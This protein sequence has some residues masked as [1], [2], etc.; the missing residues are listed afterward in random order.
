MRLAAVCLLLCCWPLPLRAQPAP[1]HTVHVTSP[2][3]A[4]TEAIVRAVRR[5]LHPPN[6]VQAATSQPAVLDQET[7]LVLL[8]LTPFSTED[9]P[10]RFRVTA[11]Q[12]PLL[13][14]DRSLDVQESPSRVDL[15]ETVAI[16]FPEMLLR[17]AEQ[18]RPQLPAQ[19]VPLPL[20]PN[21]LPRTPRSTVPPSPGAP[22]PIQ[23]ALT[24]S[25][26]KNP[27][28]RTEAAP[29]VA[30]PPPAP[31][32]LAAPVSHAPSP[33]PSAPKLPP[34]PSPPPPVDAPRTPHRT[35]AAAL[36][37]SGSATL[38]AG[39]ATG[40]LSLRIASQV[41][42][43]TS[44]RF[45]AELDA[46]GRALG[47]AAIVLDSVGAAAVVGGIAVLAIAAKR[48]SPAITVQPLITQGHVG[49]L[50]QGVLR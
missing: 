8:S 16:G 41:S 29:E 11:T 28:G 32:T 43:P 25:R 4:L 5:Y 46:R 12:G 10:R 44:P 21:R 9:P 2:D 19:P 47:T 17:L 36:L 14:I 40:V 39:L 42:H 6:R 7:T 34:A 23:L 30:Q 27:V 26:T 33:V 15:A 22:R 24:D 38:L 48:R 20:V 18:A 1:T 37:A 45:P 50:V 3:A 35:A 13:R 31:P 49:L